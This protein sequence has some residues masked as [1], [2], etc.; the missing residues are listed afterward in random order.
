M[1]ELTP[2]LET[3]PFLDILE[4]E[5]LEQA[6]EYFT[7]ETLSSGDIILTPGGI[8]KKLYFIFSGLVFSYNRA[9]NI[10]WYEF[11]GN[12]FTD[13]NSFYTQKPSENF[14]E[15]AEDRTALL[16]IKYDKLKNLYKMSH[17][18]ALWGTQFKEAEIVRLVS[19][20]E[21]LRVK[22]ASQRYSDLVASYPEALQRIPLGHIASYLGVSQVSLSRIRAGSQKKK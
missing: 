7:L 22:D 4:M 20:Y 3:M 17:K 12:A 6:S 2:Y 11:E 16:S 19:Y 13:I 10:L 18:W 15:V 8:C 5:D 14:I 9:R 21:S 1:D